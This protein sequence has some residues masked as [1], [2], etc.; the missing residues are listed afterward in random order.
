MAHQL[1]FVVEA[2]ESS[3]SDNIYIRSV[4]D[5]YF[6]FRSRSDIKVNTVYMDGRG[7]YKKRNIIN[8]I[9]KFAK[10]YNKLG[11]TSVIYCFDT[12]K[13]DCDPEDKNKFEEEANYCRMNDY[14]FVW[15]CHDVEEVF[16]GKS[17]DKNEKTNIAKQYSSND[18][19]K[20]VKKSNLRS[21]KMT[22]GKTN[23]LFVLE[24]YYSK[25]AGEK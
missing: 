14:D 16:V 18:G 22:K 8:K 9:N 2:A 13:F 15:F 4:L 20:K 7:N 3:K 25:D 11:A 21:T 17:V 19:I 5:E 12:D 10:E 24:K 1:I 23:L 6:D